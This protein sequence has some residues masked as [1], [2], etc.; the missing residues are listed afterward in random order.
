MSGNN[1]SKPEKSYLKQVNTVSFVTLAGNVILSAA[2][3]VGGIV[4]SSSALISDAVHS[5]SDC[6]ST[7]VVLIGVR[8]AT[9]KS[10]KEHP[11][12]HEKMECIAALALAALLIATAGWI[13]YGG[14]ATVVKIAQG[15][16][17]SKPGMGALFIAASSILLKGWMYFYTEHYAKKLR[18]TALHGDAVHHLS[19]SLSSVGAI[20]G[21]GGSML[22]LSVADPIASLVIAI[23]IFKA[24]WDILRVAVDQL[25]DKAAD[26]ETE[27]RIKEEACKVPGVVRVD[28]LRTRQHANKIFADMEIAVSADLSLVEAHRIAEAVHERVE[29]EIGENVKHCMVHVNPATEEDNHETPVSEMED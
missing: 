17:P 16:T 4:A 6:F 3:L 7:V 18:S 21:I 28:V 5:L 22:G 14:V 23:F 2:K 11:Y 15:Y 25:V 10:D 19:D 8:A 20:A 1:A 29:H 12:G 9:K 27:T 24:A 13:A 26:D